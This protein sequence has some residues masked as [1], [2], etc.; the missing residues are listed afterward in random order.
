[1]KQG[2]MI[3]EHTWAGFAFM[4][5]MYCVFSAWGHEKEIEEDKRL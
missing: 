2:L 1:M 4:D 3:E 5:V